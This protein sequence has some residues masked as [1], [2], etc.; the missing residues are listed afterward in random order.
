LI[1]ISPISKKG[2]EGSRQE[3]YQQEEYQ[4]GEYQEGEYQEGVEYSTPDDNNEGENYG[5]D[6]ENPDDFASVSDSIE[7]EN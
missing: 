6:A 7:P 1:Q 3:E 4:E 5:A 2:D